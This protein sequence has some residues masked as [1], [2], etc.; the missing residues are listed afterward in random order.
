[1]NYDYYHSPEYKRMLA[2]RH[3]EREGREYKTKEYWVKQKA[4][5]QA[6]TLRNTYF[7]EL[8]WAFDRIISEQHWDFWDN[9]NKTDGCWIWTGHI[10]SEGYGDCGNGRSAHRVAYKLATGQDPGELFVLHKCDTPA[11]VRP[12]HLF[13]GTHLDNVRDMDTKGRRGDCRQKLN[14]NDVVTIRGLQ[15]TASKKVVAAQFG[16]STKQVQ[17]I[18]SGKRWPVDGV[19]LPRNTALVSPR[20]PV[21]LS[22]S[23]PLLFQEW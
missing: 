14:L 23:P 22:P 16:I 9:V 15:G 5:H 11:C 7:R 17:R 21:G 12:D 10:D 6:T 20:P 3:A 19:S 13:L 1:M 18:W 4:E 8:L 2:R